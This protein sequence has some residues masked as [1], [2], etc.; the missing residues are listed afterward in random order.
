MK[1]SLLTQK[2]FCFGVVVRRNQEERKWIKPTADLPPSI[3]WSA[4]QQAGRTFYPQFT[5]AGLE[6][7]LAARKVVRPWASYHTVSVYISG[8]WWKS[9]LL[10]SCWRSIMQR[11]NTQPVFYS[12]VISSGTMLVPYG[13]VVDLCHYINWGWPKNQLVLY[14]IF[15]PNPM[16]YI[17]ILPRPN[18]ALSVSK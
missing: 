5:V 9:W 11:H 6:G 10:N 7:Q 16:N 2:L 14:H 18:N 17:K 3:S 8:L 4:V 13:T 15:F 12:R 1:T